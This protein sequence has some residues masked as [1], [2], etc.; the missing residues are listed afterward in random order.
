MH[1]AIARNISL[2]SDFVTLVKLIK[3]FRQERYSAVHSVAPKAGLLAMLASWIVRVPLRIHTFTGQV[4]VT[5][6]GFK[7]L[8]LKQL[9]CLIATLTTHNIVDSQ[10]QRQFLLDEKVLSSKKSV[11]FANGSIS[12]VDITKFKPNQ[13][14]RVGIRQ[15]LFIP[16]NAIVFL[17]IGRLTRDKGV[18]DLACAFSCLNVKHVYLLYVGPDEQNMQTEIVHFSGK[19]SPNVIFL[20]H[21]NEPESYMAAADIFCLPS[22]RE[23]FGTVVIEAAAVG[24]PVIASRIYGITDAIVEGET[25]LLHEPHDINNI[26]NCMEK[27]MNNQALRLKLGQQARDRVIR[28]FSS[29]LVTQAWVNFYFENM[30]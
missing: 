18:L 21:T 6:R 19:N 13:L 12:G 26:K 25:G 22:Y 24:I 23:G 27:L 8:L 30:R 20:G 29:I 9:D 28:D 16:N 17:F 11:M 3:I 1:L 15:K 14:A 7:R 5:N 2:F 10:S 4:W